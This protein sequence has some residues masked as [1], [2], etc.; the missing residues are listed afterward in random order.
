MISKEENILFAAEKLF[1]RKGFRGTSTREI[2]REANVNISMISYYFGSKEQLYEK[3]LEYRSKEGQFFSKE[4]I[5]RKDINEWEKLKLTINLFTERVRS[6]RQFYTILQREQLYTNNPRIM[7]Y[8]KD[9]KMSFISMYSRLLEDGIA[10]GVFTKKPPVSFLH[11]TV[12][13]TLF[14]ACNAKDMYKTFMK[15]E[16]PEEVYDENYYKE[17]NQHLKNIL[18]H[19]L[20]YDEN[21]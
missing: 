6:H 5:E 4:I 19:L 7:Q 8:L 1:A 14:Y 2:S 21:K 17:L 3:L 18:K 12:S 11:S 9:T 15:N 20:G 16:E 10:S 13:G